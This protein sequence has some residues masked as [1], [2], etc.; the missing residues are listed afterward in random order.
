MVELVYI[1]YYECLLVISTNDNEILAKYY[2]VEKLIYQKA[3]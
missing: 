1:I 2:F 3:F